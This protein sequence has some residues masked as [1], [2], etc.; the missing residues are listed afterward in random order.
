M[1]IEDRTTPRGVISWKESA[2]PLPERHLARERLV[3]AIEAHFANQRRHGPV[4]LMVAPAGYGKTTA[5][6]QWA[7]TSLFPVAWYTLDET[8]NDLVAFLRG[9]TRAL[10][11]VVRRPRWRVLMA[12]DRLQTGIPASSDLDRLK[13]LFLD[14]LRRIVS[15]P[16]TLAITNLHVLRPE[17]PAADLVER[18]LTEQPDLLGLA[19]ESREPRPI[20]ATTL[21]QEQ[22]LRAMGADELALTDEE[23]HALLALLDAHLTAQ[24]TRKLRALCDGWIMGVTLATDAGVSA[25]LGGSG[26]QPQKL[27]RE[28]TLEYLTR[29]VIDAL[30]ATERAFA[31][32]VALLDPVTP[33]V[34]ARLLDLPDARE[35]LGALERR[36]SFFDAVAVEA[37][38][39]IY[40]FQPAVRA[41]L[42][43]ELK[44][45]LGAAPVR[46]LHARAGDILRDAGKDEE[47]VSHYTRAKRFDRIVSLIEER[48]GSLLR[49]GH[50][51]SVVRWIEEL[52]AAT[53]DSRPRLQLLLAELRRS[54][55]RMKSAWQAA[56][57]ACALALPLA[58][59]EPE[60]AAHAFLTR[61]MLYFTQGEYKSAKADC[62]RALAIT[63]AD[64]DTLQI[65][66]R[67]GLVSCLSALH[68]L[69]QIDD[70]LS[71]L[72]RRAQDLRDV[73]TLGR[74]W[75][76]RSKAYQA[77]MRYIASGKA[78]ERALLYA[79]EAEDV[80]IAVVSQIQLGMM[81]A[82]QGRY[83]EALALVESAREQA[84]RAGY[85]LGMAYAVA[86]VGDVERMRGAYDE[87]LAGYYRAQIL[88]ERLTDPALL[89]LVMSGL[90]F[91][92]ILNG[93]SD[94]AVSLLR[95]GYEQA[96]DAAHQTPWARTA[97]T[98]GLGYLREGEPAEAAEPIERAYAIALH[99]E[100]PS[101]L[102][103][104]RLFLCALRLAQNREA[105][106]TAEVIA[107]L[108]ALAVEDVAPVLLPTAQI[109]AEVFPLMENLNDERASV[110]LAGLARA[111][112][113]QPAEIE[114]RTASQA[115][116][117]VYTFGGGRVFE[118]NIQLTHWRLPAAREMLCY[119]LDRREPVRK[120]VLLAE[121]WPDKTEQIA[122][123]NFRQAVF[124]LNRVLDRKTMVKREGRWSLNFDCWMDAR[125]FERLYEEGERLA[126]AGELRPAITALRQALTYYR[127]RYLEDVDSA[128]ARLR[129]ERF[130]LIQLSC[131]EQL[132]TLEERLGRYDDAAQRW[133]QLLEDPTPHES[134]R[135]GLMR[136][137][138][139]RQEYA[140][141]RD[142]YD[143]LR[144]ELGPR[145]A[146]S[147]ETQA[148]YRELMANA[149]TP[150]QVD[151]G[152]DEES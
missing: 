121:L 54:A 50:G 19:L 96:P 32:R 88:T 128:W 124:Q 152:R 58:A 125:E 45:E 89:S 3:A 113:P 37:N 18:L 63:P 29:Q 116:L 1:V 129:A 145:L 40:R 106:A 20:P 109:I 67:F 112:R 5:L 60:L 16:V 27:N 94:L 78:A 135:R 69:D 28:A 10:G 87:A 122:N 35:R 36:M 48:R 77:D 25:V 21:R 75:Y 12:L 141:V 24:D 22:R 59:Q 107:A 15:R 140:N 117:R 144:R 137:Y 97:L 119:L 101:L 68:Q 100:D 13:D 105:E 71:G 82:C 51:E 66:A 120:D 111:E 142:Q 93:R 53:R 26:A 33:S 130:A 8:D 92:Y 102:L 115:A 49:A 86:S 133:F 149:R 95:D 55:G 114:R 6:A 2:P 23:F 146:P 74:Y 85:G 61:G 41:S 136:Y 143:R 73:A 7:Q 81:L 104:A 44:S 76:L 150:A 147:P 70:L 30:P 90:G 43:R 151:T 134:A 39:T 14:D 131:L 91:T 47:A 34:C 123:I 56:R 17:E 64:A 42:L 132:A 11:S 84:R 79:Q 72:E 62:E 65:Q 98:L 83:T 127:G 80:H 52:P 148:L 57:A 110:L 103:D 4:L 118:G 9:V 31:A 46:E 126:A 99:S 108:H 138:A 139:R 38:E